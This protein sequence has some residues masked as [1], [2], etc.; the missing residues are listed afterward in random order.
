MKN[1]NKKTVVLTLGESTDSRDSSVNPSLQGNAVNVW[2]TVDKAG[3]QKGASRRDVPT[4]SR[5]A[6]RT[7]PDSV[8]ELGFSGEQNT[9][10]PSLPAQS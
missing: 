1:N 8:A 5:G 2:F 6:G 7:W 10:V 3:S 4:E 9:C